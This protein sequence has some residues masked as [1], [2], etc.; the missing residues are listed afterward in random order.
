MTD[1]P[2]SFRVEVLKPDAAGKRKGKWLDAIDA[3]TASRGTYVRH[4]YA[5]VEG[6][7][8]GGERLDAIRGL[9]SRSEGR[10]TEFVAQK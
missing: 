1:A 9:S 5:A 7:L 10:L 6:I 4:L 3:N 8:R 2:C